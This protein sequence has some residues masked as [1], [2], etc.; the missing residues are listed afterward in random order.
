MP[1]DRNI[2]W[3][4]TKE[5]GEKDLEHITDFQTVVELLMNAALVSRPDIS[6]AVAALSCYN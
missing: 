1:V 4:L 6:Y 3:D 2:R 5:W